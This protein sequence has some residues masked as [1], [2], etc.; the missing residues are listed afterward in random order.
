MRFK[1]SGQVSL[2]P[3]FLP[4]SLAIPNLRVSISDNVYAKCDK[5]TKFHFDFD[6]VSVS[7]ETAFGNPNLDLV[8]INAYAKFDH[9]IP[10]WSR[11]T[12]S[13][14]NA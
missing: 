14:T 2:R 13:F 6:F 3:F 1:S 5:M 8:N 11:F 10:Y 12:T 4:P 7:E 9:N